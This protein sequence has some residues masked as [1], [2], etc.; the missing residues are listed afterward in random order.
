MSY[1]ASEIMA[2]VL[3]I[4]GGIL[5][6]WPFLRLWYFR[7]RQAILGK[8]I[9]LAYLVSALIFTA[10]YLALFKIDRYF[11]EGP[12]YD[13]AHVPIS[14]FLGGNTFFIWLGYPAVLLITIW[15]SGKG[16]VRRILSVLTA[17][18]L[19]LVMSVLVFLLSAKF[20]GPTLFWTYN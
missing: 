10:V 8:K 17:L 7:H 11:L 4:L 6:A 9:A 14:N 3:G 2:W 16:Y 13:V 19:F 20:S 18:V 15:L 1:L 12:F 5:V